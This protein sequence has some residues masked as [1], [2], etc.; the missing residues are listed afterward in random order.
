MNVWKPIALCAIAGLAASIG[1]QAAKA[2]P[3]PTPHPW[4]QGCGAG[5]PNMMNAVNSLQTGLGYLQKADADKG[6]H[7]ANAIT[8]ANTAIAE[9]NAGCEYH[10]EH[11]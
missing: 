9:T 8:A 4:V 10:R 6:G 1:I 3:N 2:N 7:R 11:P 5:Q